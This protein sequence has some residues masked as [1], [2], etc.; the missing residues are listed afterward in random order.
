MNVLSNIFNK[1]GSYGPLLLHFLSIYLLWNK[2]NLFFYYIIGI[3]VNDISN[4]ILKGIFLQPRPSVDEKL[5]ELALKNSRRF[6]FKDGM[7]YD[8]LGMPSGHSQ[9]VIFSTVFIY[10]ALRKK[11][12]LY[13]YLLI[14]LLT[15]IQRV[16][17]NHHTVL[18]VFIGALIGAL[19]G[20]L[21]YYLAT[22][23]MK[24]LIREK[25][26]DFGPL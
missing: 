11:N 3:F 25:I 1:L 15:M 6:L 18:Q 21:F 7:P 26:D 4:I 23:K 16:L 8:V 14:S 20:Y 12:I 5:F 24:G 19:V 13:V 10:L 2:Q 9:S 17:R 22:Q